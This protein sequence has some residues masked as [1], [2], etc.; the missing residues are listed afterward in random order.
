MQFSAAIFF[1]GKMTT[2]IY[3]L[4][5]FHIFFKDHK[6]S[7]IHRYLHCDQKIVSSERCDF[8][9][10]QLPELLPSA[11]ISLLAAH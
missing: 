2:F 3:K 8:I 1:F 10:I 6:S 9:K 7:I 11:Y 5:L 4:M